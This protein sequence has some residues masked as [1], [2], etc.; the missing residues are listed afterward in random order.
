VYEEAQPYNPRMDALSP[1]LA[2]LLADAI[3]AL[4]VGIVAFVVLGTLVI[5]AGRPLGW[6][7]VR[8]RAFRIAHLALMVFIALQ[9]WLGQLCPLTVWEQA[10]RNRAGQATYGESFIQHWLSRMIFFEAPW[11]SFVAAYTAFAALVIACWW[12]V[13]PHRRRA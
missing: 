4:H 11:W 3:L 8:N 9:A 10:L 5:L 1:T 12:W 13:P 6:S 7:W 2:R